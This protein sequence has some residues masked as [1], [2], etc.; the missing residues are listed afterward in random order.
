MRYLRLYLHFLRF[1]FSKAMEFRLDFTFRI[2]MDCVFYLVQFM[3]FHII[4]LHTPLIGGWDLSQMRVFVASYILIDALHMTIFANNCWWFPIYINRGDLDYYLTKP[5]S[6]FFFLSLREFAANSFLNLLIAIGLLS[7][8]L[9]QYPAPLETSKLIL[10]IFLLLNGTFMYF[11]LYMIFLLSV[12]WTESPRGFGDL[13][14]SI[15]HTLERPD[16]IFKGIIRKLFIYVFPF[17]L[18]ASFPARVL[19]EVDQTSLVWTI[20]SVTIILFSIVMGLWKLGLRDYS[21]ASS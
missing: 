6:T 1:S 21:S 9:Y 2:F 17:A 15:S 8:T 20:M 11:L 18:M 19:L 14:F 12:F 13:Y 4:Y 10:F 16:A 7:W 5:V 3:F